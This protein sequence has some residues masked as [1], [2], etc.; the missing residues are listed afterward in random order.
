MAA[1]PVADRE[2]VRRVVG[3]EVRAPELRDFARAQP[4]ERREVQ[5]LR[6]RCFGRA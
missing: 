4:A 2:S 5:V 3:E 6:D 1:F